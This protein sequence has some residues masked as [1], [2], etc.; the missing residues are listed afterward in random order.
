MF[1]FLTVLVVIALASATDLVIEKT[2]VPEKCTEKSKNG[3]TLY[4]HYSGYIAQSRYLYM[5]IIESVIVTFIFMFILTIAFIAPQE[6]LVQSSI[7]L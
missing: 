3:D 5:K 4:M 6:L 1:R 2:F 7:A